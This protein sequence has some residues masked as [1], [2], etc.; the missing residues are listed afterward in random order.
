[1]K[2]VIKNTIS[3]IVAV[4][5]FIAV[6][7][8]LRYLLGDDSKTSSRIV[9]HELYTMDENIDTVFLGS[10]HVYRSID[11]RVTDG[12]LQENTFDLATSGQRIDGSFAILKEACKYHDIK[13]VYL[14]MYNHIIWD[15]AQFS[16][17][18]EM[19]ST[20]EVSDYMRCSVDRISLILN[21]SAPKYYSNA[22]I[23]AR[24]SWEKV[25]DPEYIDKIKLYN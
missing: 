10:S 6:G 22:F 24:R 1:M 4:A 8:G 18:D 16:E 20:Y 2:R 15:R 17:R 3:V 14:E 7:I 12:Y 11:P 21:S 5:L 23:V 9:F 13:H 19:T 25:F